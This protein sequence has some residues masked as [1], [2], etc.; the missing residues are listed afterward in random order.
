[1]KRLVMP[2]LCLWPVLAY[3]Q[4]MYT[5]ADLVKFQVPGAYTNEDLRALQRVPAARV[6]AALPPLVE[7]PRVETGEIEKEYEGLLRERRALAAELAWELETIEYSESAFAGST[8]RVEPRAGYRSRVASLVWEL[9]KR[10]ALL[11]AEIETV[12]DE[13]RRTG[14]LLD[15]R[16][17]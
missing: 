14:A 2:A 3:G 7:A 16:D 5:N 11:D 10:V 1:M 13:A 8:D 4:Q 17:Q 12:L 9:K 6:P 15:R